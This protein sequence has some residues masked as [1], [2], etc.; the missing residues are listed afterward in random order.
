[1]RRYQPI[2]HRAA[3]LSPSPLGRAPT[4]PRRRPPARHHTGVRGRSVRGESV[5]GALGTLLLQAQSRRL[6]GDVEATRRATF[7]PAWKKSWRRANAPQRPRAGLLLASDAMNRGVPVNR[8][9]MRAAQ[10]TLYAAV[11]D[12]SWDVVQVKVRVAR[13]SRFRVGRIPTESRAARRPSL[14][15]HDPPDIGTTRA[16][17]DPAHRP[18]DSCALARSSPTSRR[19]PR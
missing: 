4:T 9:S 17:A 8:R 12:G 11:R 10:T 5:I 1:M 19:P 6:T 15:R 16:R 18:I 13:L 2:G 3:T 7:R 14:L